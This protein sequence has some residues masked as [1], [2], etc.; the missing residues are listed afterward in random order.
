MAV[1]EYGAGL[2]HEPSLALTLP[3]RDAPT[4]SAGERA[5]ALAFRSQDMALCR[6]ANELL[7]ARALT[8]PATGDQTHCEDLFIRGSR[9]YGDAKF[10]SMQNSTVQG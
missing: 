2:G 8:G 9:V 5:F 7:I 10:L 6:R 1:V 3:Y 4:A